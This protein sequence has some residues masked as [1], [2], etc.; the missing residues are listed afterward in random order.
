MIAAAMKRWHTVL[1][2]VAFLFLGG[3]PR[4]AVAQTVPR[5]FV[6]IVTGASG[7]PRFATGFHA[8]AMALRASA[9]TRLGIPD[10]LITYLAEDPSVDPANIKGKSTREGV[11]QA[12]EAIAARAKPAD[13][14]MIL[15]LGHGSSQNDESRFS[16]PGPDLTAPEFAKLIDRLSAQTVAFVD[17]SSASGEFI[18]RLAGPKR[19]IVTATKSGFEGNE[20]LFGLHFVEAYA[21][22]G[23]D[24]DKDG[25]VSILEA[26]VFAKREVQREYE[27]SNRLQT[28]HA[29]LDDDGDG[30]GHGDPSEKGPDG[31]RARAFFLAAGAGVSS[32]VA[33]N[34][35]AAALLETQRRTQ[36]EIDSLR[37]L[38]PGM[39]EEDFQKALE[40]LMLKL[41][42]TTQELKA[43]E[44]KKP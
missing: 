18:K 1:A 4:L 9:T 38:R 27:S 44:V 30:V 26:F 15:L 19:I 3:A 37:A 24:T 42:T 7:E 34:P 32:A 25:R 31:V 39:T 11:T 12:I 16:M 5:T 41:A 43:L 10:S 40:P 28:E 22:E 35:K 8:Q 14:V 33:A 2:G 17:A 13:N 21:N 6:L 29:M 36:A 23:A 20:T